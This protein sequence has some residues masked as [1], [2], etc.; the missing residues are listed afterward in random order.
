MPVPDVV[1]APSFAGP[2]AWTAV[3]SSVGSL[4]H[5][6]QARR[7]LE[8]KQIVG[9]T[10]NSGVN[11]VIAFCVL[12]WKFPAAANESP[13]FLIGLSAA[14]GLGQASVLDMILTAVRA[15]AAQG[16]RP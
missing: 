7:P 8:A 12:T 16:D 10:L 11:G 15:R 13:L 6:L 2:L 5:A 4:A 3:L 14:A 9:A 1:D